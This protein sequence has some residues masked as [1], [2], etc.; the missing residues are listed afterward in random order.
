MTL[1]S[2]LLGIVMPIGHVVVMVGKALPGGLLC[3]QQPS[4]LAEYVATG[5]C[6]TQLLWMRQMLEDYGLAQSCF[7]IYYDNMS[8]IDI[9]KNPV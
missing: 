5:S 1:V 4:C 6:C 9:S 3:R 2:I 7:L 8:G